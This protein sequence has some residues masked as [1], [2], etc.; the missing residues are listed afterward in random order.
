MFFIFLVAG[1]L[2]LGGWEFQYIV[3]RTSYFQLKS[4]TV[5][6]NVNV[7]REEIV[8]LAGFTLQ[9]NVFEIDPKAAEAMIGTHP[10]IKSVHV[11]RDTMRSLK[12]ETSE[13]ASV[14]LA[15]GAGKFFEIDETGFVAG[16]AT[17]KPRIDLPIITNIP[18]SQLVVGTRITDE[19]TFALLRWISGV[20]ERYLVN[21]SELS[22]EKN[23]IVALTL[24]GVKVYPGPPATFMKLYT[25]FAATLDKFD[26]DKIPISYVDMRFNDE[27]VIRPLQL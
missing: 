12:I 21:I 5:E 24:E 16:M 6:G 25:L 13:R 3:F 22:I 17:K 19:M 4:I 9:E 1:L 11:T 20:D 23:E 2:V 7:S 14:A 10:R 15:V 18:E 26:R 27:I 8:K